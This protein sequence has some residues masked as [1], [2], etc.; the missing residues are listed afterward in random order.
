MIED[1]LPRLRTYFLMIST[2]S[3]V[4]GR[5]SRAQPLLVVLINIKKPS[6]E[7]GLLS[8]VGSSIKKSVDLKAIV[9]NGP[10]L[11]DIEP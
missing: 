10:K 1:I 5:L 11:Q 2:I 8:K 7:A 3:C 6:F 9:R 4:G